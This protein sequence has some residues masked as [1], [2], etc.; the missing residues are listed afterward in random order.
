MGVSGQSQAP[1]ALYPRGKE[2]RTHWT[3][4]GVGLRAGLNKD[5]RGKILSPLPGSNLDRSVVEPVIRHYTD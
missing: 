3:G 4:G 1:V 2:P 5:A